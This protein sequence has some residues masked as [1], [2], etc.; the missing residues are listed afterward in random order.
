[1]D[2]LVSA[3]PGQP[4]TNTRAKFC[5]DQTLHHTLFFSPCSLN[6]IIHKSSNKVIVIT[7]NYV[8]VNKGKIDE[9]GSTY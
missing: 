2:K 8:L 4:S 5:T 6:G 3:L 7:I 9:G 1:M